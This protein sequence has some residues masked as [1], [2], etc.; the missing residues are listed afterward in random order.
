MTQQKKTILVV[1][2]DSDFGKQLSDKGFDVKVCSVNDKAN[3]GKSC[4]SASAVFLRWDGSQGQAIQVLDMIKNL[5]KDIEQ[6]PPPVYLTADFSLKNDRMLKGNVERF[7]VAAVFA[8][9]EELHRMDMTLFDLSGEI[10]EDSGPAFIRRSDFRPKSKIELSAII[11]KSKDAFETRRNLVNSERNFFFF[12]QNPEMAAS[13]VTNLVASG[14]KNSRAFSNIDQLL[15][16]L[17]DGA[18]DVLMVYHAQNPEVTKLLLERVTADRRNNP[19]RIMVICPGPTAM[20]DF[21]SVNTHSWIDHKFECQFNK[22]GIKLAL[23][24]LEG[25]GGAEPN[26][27]GSLLALRKLIQEINP[28]DA[29]SHNQFVWNNILGLAKLPGGKYWAKLEYLFFCLVSANHE[30]ALDEAN[31]L[32]LMNPFSIEIALVQL[33]ALAKLGLNCDAEY[34]ALNKVL[35]TAATISGEEI[36]SLTRFVSVQGDI[37]RFKAILERLEE[38]VHPDESALHFAK[39]AYAEL[40]GDRFAEG[41]WLRLAVF[42]NPIRLLYLHKLAKYF[43]A[44]GEFRIAVK[45]TELCS[46]ADPSRK[47][48]FNISIVEYLIADGAVMR[49]EQKMIESLREFP[50][51]TRVMTAAAQFFPDAYKGMVDKYLPKKKQAAS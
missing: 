39:S 19:G 23:K 2:L 30:K 14:I 17:A 13:G 18:P 46:E 40:L 35:A 42:G 10:E 33:N 11:R 15:V 45:I 12:A 8:L 26:A 43:S 21:L 44:T 28:R 34:A 47:Y 3:I 36:I 51:N 25:L 6:V 50:G 1:G 4:T 32:L 38:I 48:L 9:P 16:K 37:D 22:S 27:R 24:E 49:A 5:F 20:T 29:A 7:K 31:E 41:G